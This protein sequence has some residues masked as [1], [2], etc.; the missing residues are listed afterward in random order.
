MLKRCTVL[1]IV[2]L[3]FLLCACSFGGGSSGGSSGSMSQ[4]VATNSVVSENSESGSSSIGDSTQTAGSLDVSSNKSDESQTDLEIEVPVVNGSQAEKSPEECTVEDAESYA[5]SYAELA[6]TAA[7]NA[8]NA[9]TAEES[10]KYAELA[11]IYADKAELYAEQAGTESAKNAA[12]EANDAVLVA[13]V[14]AA[15]KMAELYAELAKSAAENAANADSAEKAEQFLKEASE[16]AEKAGEYAELAGTDVAKEAAQ[17]AEKSAENAKSSFDLSQKEEQLEQYIEDLIKFIENSSSAGS[18]E[19]AAALENQADETAAKANE[20]AYEIAQI[21]GEP[22]G[23]YVSKIEIAV[24]EAMLENYAKEAAAAAEN[25]A[26]AGT[27]EEAEKYAKQAQEAAE[28]AKAI[29]TQFG[30]NITENANKL[31][32]EAQQSAEAAVNVSE[33][34]KAFEEASRQADTGLSYTKEDNGVYCFSVGSLNYKVFIES[35]NS[36]KVEATGSLTGLSWTKNYTK[37]GNQYYK[38]VDLGWIKYTIPA[39]IMDG[40][41]KDNLQSF[42]ENIVKDI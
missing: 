33:E 4:S 40:L 31:I 23:E 18:A 20:L 5:K 17:E 2:F 7:D 32:S 3:T 26:T 15:E 11:K 38:T 41:V 27:A 39:F 1:L 30:D 36:V 35:E 21:K 19:D 42:F 22:V 10:E 9:E 13:K 14:A 25:A 34:K 6:K 8:V 16:A 28:H 12:Q 24:A 29:G 37:K